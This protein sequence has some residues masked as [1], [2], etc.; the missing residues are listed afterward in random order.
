M[1]TNEPFWQRG[2]RNG[3]AEGLGNNG[4]EDYKV[5]VIFAGIF[6]KVHETPQRIHRLATSEEGG[7]RGRRRKVLFLS[8]CCD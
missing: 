6:E 4:R 7:L 3:A 5:W 2:G 8:Y 1:E